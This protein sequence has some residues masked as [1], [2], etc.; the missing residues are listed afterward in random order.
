MY[1]TTDKIVI[2]VDLVNN[3]AQ[4]F[5]AIKKHLGLT[6]NTEVIRSLIRSAYKEVFS[7]S[8]DEV[9]PLETSVTQEE[10]T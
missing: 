7:Q 10:A 3:A 2:R 8:P 6:Q 4:E 1:K 9:I 5:E